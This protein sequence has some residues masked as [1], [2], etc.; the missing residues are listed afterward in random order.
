MKCFRTDD[1]S[2]VRCC[3]KNM[4]DMFQIR[5]AALTT[6]QPPK[7]WENKRRAVKRTMCR[8]CAHLSV[9]VE[10]L[11]Q[12]SCLD[13]QWKENWLQQG[14]RRK[15]TRPTLW[16]DGDVTRWFVDG[17]Y[18]VLL[19]E[20]NWSN[21]AASH[22]NVL[23]FVSERSVDTQKRAHVCNVCARTRSNVKVGLLGRNRSQT[24]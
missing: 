13:Q 8:A 23:T 5:L 3:G 16:N 17:G 11:N 6:T 18:I 24:T 2:G 19:R 21:S 20:K 9:F 10:L 7:E 15:K 22:P 1:K 12:V 4:G 14:M